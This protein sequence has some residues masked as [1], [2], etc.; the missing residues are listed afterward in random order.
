[1]MRE[2]SMP[3]SSTRTDRDPLGFFQTTGRSATR[4]TLIKIPMSC[5][6]E[7]TN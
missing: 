5:A 1:L 6:T 3:T 7:R 2:Q 4:P